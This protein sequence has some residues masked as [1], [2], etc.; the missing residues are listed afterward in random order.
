M[1]KELRLQQRLGQGRAADLNQGRS[2]AQTVLMEGIGH[3]FFPRAAFPD[4]EDRGIGF[5]HHL[6]LVQDR[7]HLAVG[8]QNTV[9]TKLVF[10]LMFQILIF[11]P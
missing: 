8:P 11:S 6:D 9:K 1:P 5:R 10:E 4:D 2:L 7:P 3:Q